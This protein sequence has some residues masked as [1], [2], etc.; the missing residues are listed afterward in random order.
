MGTKEKSVKSENQ[1]S[2]VEVE[3]TSECG[4]EFGYFKVGKYMVSQACAVS[5]MEAGVLRKR[6]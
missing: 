5:L 3:I 2:L 1:D 6:D 4:N